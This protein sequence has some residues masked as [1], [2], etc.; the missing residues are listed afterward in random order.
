MHNGH[1]RLSVTGADFEPLE[2]VTVTVRV[3]GK[4]GCGPDFDTVTGVEDV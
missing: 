2:S 3:A 1:D 4:P